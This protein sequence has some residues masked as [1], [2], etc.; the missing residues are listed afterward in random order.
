MIINHMSS[1]PKK[2][3]QIALLEGL[4]AKILGSGYSADELIKMNRSEYNKALGKKIGSESSF[5][6]QIRRVN[7][8]QDNINQVQEAYI[9]KRTD[10]SK[11]TV[12]AIKQLTERKFEGLK[13]VSVIDTPVEKARLTIF[14]KM[15]KDLMN[16]HGISERKA[17]VRARFLLRIPK[18]DYR[19]LRRV[20][21]VILAHYGY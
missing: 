5:K 7:Q 10:K 18:K 2:E 3:S 20:D 1:N 11:S 19:K 13:F 4:Y 15:T 8:I 14:E 6:A 16:K 17:I 21:K 9:K 12:S